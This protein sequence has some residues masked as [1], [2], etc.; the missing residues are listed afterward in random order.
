MAWIWFFSAMDV[1]KKGSCGEDPRAR[2]EKMANGVRKCSCKSND[3][4][5]LRYLD[6]KKRCCGESMRWHSFRKYFG[7]LS[8]CYW[9][10]YTCRWW[11]GNS[12]ANSGWLGKVKGW[13]RFPQFRGWSSATTGLGKRWSQ[14]WG[15]PLSTN[16]WR[17]FSFLE[18]KVPVKTLQNCQPSPISRLSVTSLKSVWMSRFPEISIIS[19]HKYFCSVHY[20]IN[21]GYID[22]RL[23][24][25]KYNGPQKF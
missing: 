18:L 7:F 3:G 21:S 8:L 5:T 19:F 1:C 22:F 9:Y 13:R 10:T 2:C 17:E 23:Y 4:S 25:R 11:E 16:P 12:I 6:K 14:S 20:I 15:R 24:G